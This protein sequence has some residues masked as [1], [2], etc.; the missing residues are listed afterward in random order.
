MENLVEKGIIAKASAWKKPCAF[1]AKKL[2]PSPIFS[3]NLFPA[4]K[5]S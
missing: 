2:T 5:V 3:L 1:P 4:L